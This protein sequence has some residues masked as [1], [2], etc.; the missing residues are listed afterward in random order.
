MPEISVSHEAVGVAVATAPHKPSNWIR[1]YP[2]AAL[3]LVGVLVGAFL[4]LLDPTSSRFAFAAIALVC[5]IPVL[6]ATARNMVAGRF[7]VDTIAALAIVAAVLEREFVAAALVVLMQSGGEAI[8][9]FGLRRAN[10]SLDNLLKRAPSI[11]HR[12]QDDEFVDVAAADLEAGDVV[13]IRPGDIIAA[14]GRVVDGRGSVDE[15]ALTGEPV[16]L[17]KLPG[18]RVFSGTINIAG[19][20]TVKVTET[21]AHSKYELIVRMVQHAQGEKAPIN[22]LANQF[23][24]GFTLLTLSIAVA[25]LVATR[26]PTRA[27]SV[28]VV[29]TPCPLIIATPLAV[30]SAVNR[31]AS[32]NVI[33]KSG[34]AIEQA[35][36]VETVVFDKTGT[37]TSGE[38]SL[39]RVCLLGTAGTPV[40]DEDAIIASV[41]RLELLSPHVLAMAV[42]R[43]ARERGFSIRPAEDAEESAGSGIRGTVDGKRLHVG[44][45]SYLRR[46]G[47]QLGNLDDRQAAGA[48]RSAAYVGVDGALAA[49][50]I[51]ED[52]VR[53]EARTTV[54]RLA[55]M[56]IGAVM[57]TGDALDSA[58]SVAGHLGIAHVL[59]RMQPADKL[60][61]IKRLSAKKT[62]MMVGDG[63]NDAPALAA[64]NI[65][66][67]M[68]SFGAGVATDAAD[69]VI[70]VENVERV[71]DTIALGRRM[72]RVA[73]Q[74]ILFG[75]GGS[76]V[77]MV[78]ATR[79]LI[80]P[81]A[82]ALL[83]E[84]LDLITILN[85]FR[86][87]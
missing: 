57:L 13:L 81:A 59:A 75:I 55:R 56:G 68:G 12:M 87:R 29:A 48:G 27:L 17:T 51:F 25:A 31:A 39:A 4:F 45:E 9:D 24:P 2:I 32:W 79:G 20:Y 35:G 37:L 7:Y 3:A 47:V 44:S 33:V 61:E 84:C 74:G 36:L 41:A 23:A 15:S 46:E 66:V 16:P 53:P 78:L 52:R 43:A 26:D 30:L 28:L 77:L 50:L 73:R 67:A 5:G 71:A 86:A 80:P 76:F 54:E 62:V 22:R 14:D 1:D 34:A 21:A 60:D 18:D 6:W 85:A 8:E 69:I 11:A 10:R 82:G 58:K 49:V 64:A 70:T 65:G 72:T 42:V 19:S 40:F 38:P 63:I 83:Q